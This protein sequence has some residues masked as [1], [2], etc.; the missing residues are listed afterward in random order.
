MEIILAAIVVIVF[1]WV[2]IW[3]PSSGL[4][5]LLLFRRYGLIKSMFGASVVTVSSIVASVIGLG[6]RQPLISQ[7]P[8]M[9]TTPGLDLSQEIYQGI[10]P[11]E[12]AFALS[13]T[14][15]IAVN[16]LM[17][18]LMELIRHFTKPANAQHLTIDDILSNSDAATRPSSVDNST[19]ID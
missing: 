6:V 9:S 3:M 10:F 16:I 1:P 5:W 11:Y 4:I 7:P 18:L 13:V 19:R 12:N 8:P 14:A 15:F 17:I 2:I